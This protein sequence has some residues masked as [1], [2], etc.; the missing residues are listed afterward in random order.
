MILNY[1][2][3][4]TIIY[5]VP[6]PLYSSVYFFAMCQSTKKHE[7]RVAISVLRSWVGA[8]RKGGWIEAL[9]KGS[10]RKRVLKKAKKDQKGQSLGYVR[11]CWVKYSDCSLH[12]VRGFPLDWYGCWVTGQYCIA[13]AIKCQVLVA[14]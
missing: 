1:I 4:P 5:D 6:N 8:L 3:V 11:N 2:M 7:Y 10:T 13:Q 9:R 12:G 14:E